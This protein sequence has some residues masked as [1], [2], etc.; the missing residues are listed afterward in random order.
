MGTGLAVPTPLRWFA[1]SP[2]WRSAAPLSMT[3]K[4]APAAVP[5]SR[6]GRLA[7]IGFAAGEL[8]VGGAIEGLRRLGQPNDPKAG[9]PLFTAATARRLAERLSNLRGAAMK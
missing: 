9:N 5:Q 8:A 3:R 1:S 2:S 7:R 4:P 6:L